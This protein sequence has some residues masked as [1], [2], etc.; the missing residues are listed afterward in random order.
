MVKRFLKSGFALVILSFLLLNLGGCVTSAS[1][2]KNPAYYGTKVS[3]VAVLIQGSDQS[4]AMSVEESA[5]TRLR[6]SGI[7][8]KGFTQYVPFNSPSD[9][10]QIISDAGFEYVMAFSSSSS[11]ESYATGMYGHSGTYTPNV[12]GGG[13]YSGTTY[14][15]RST[16]TDTA[17][18]AMIYS[19]SDGAIV[20]SG[21]GQ[22]YSRGAFAVFDLSAAEGVLDELI[23]EMLADGIL[24]GR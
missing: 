22:R 3:K 13:T 4:R 24:S 6:E 17:A 7:Q 10:G 16:E 18:V 12:A 9:L 21:Q 1:G 14:Q 23:E 11:T 19:V 5:L 15:Q 8:A 2:T 20:W